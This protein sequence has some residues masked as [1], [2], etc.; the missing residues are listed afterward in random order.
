M[1]LR[2]NHVDKLT[3]D[4]FHWTAWNQSLWHENGKSWFFVTLTSVITERGETRTLLWT[5]NIRLTGYPFDGCNVIWILFTSRQSG[6]AILTETG[7]KRSSSTAWSLT[8]W[9]VWPLAP[10]RSW[11]GLPLWLEKMKL[12]FLTKVLLSPFNIVGYSQTNSA[13]WSLQC[14]IH[15]KVNLLVSTK[16]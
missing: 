3:V 15:W 11:K 9:P 6:K 2:S 10:K 5:F 12:T 1:R 14:N 16:T 4:C 8:T 7:S 13:L